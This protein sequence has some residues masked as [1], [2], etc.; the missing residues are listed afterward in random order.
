MA[1]HSSILA[2]NPRDRRAWQATGHEVAKR[3]TRLSTARY[4]TLHRE[5]QSHSSITRVH[6]RLPEEGG[7]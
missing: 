5:T 3:Q 1:T 4:S 6:G 7:I 2:E